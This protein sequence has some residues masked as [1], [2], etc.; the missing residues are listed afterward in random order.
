MTC[1][2]ATTHARV[3]EAARLVRRRAA[4][5]QHLCRLEAAPLKVSTSWSYDDLYGRLAF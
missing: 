5:R 4:G 2:A 1:P 3:L